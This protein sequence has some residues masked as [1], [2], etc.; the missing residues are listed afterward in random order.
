M[1]GI[2]P[3]M[4]SA[5]SKPEK[6]MNKSNRTFISVIIPT[7]NSA[8]TIGNT[9]QQ[10]FS[11]DFPKE[12]FEVIVVDNG[13]TDAIEQAVKNYPAR[14]L[15][16]EKRGQGPARNLGIKNAKGSIIC[17][18]DSDIIVPNDWLT[19]MSTFLQENPT[20]DAVGGAVLVPKE[21]NRN[22]IQKIMGEIYVK[23]QEFPT[24]I[25]K[26]QYLHYQGSLYTANS[27]Y[28][29]E[30]LEACNGFDESLWKRYYYHD[31]CDIDLSWR[32]VKMGKNLMFNPNIKVYHYAHRTLQG[33]YRQLVGWGA[34]YTMIRKKYG[35]HG[36]LLENLWLFNYFL[37]TLLNAVEAP[38]SK[39]RKRWLNIFYLSS[40]NLGRLIGYHRWK[41][42]RI[43]G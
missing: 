34:V 29:R 10:I 20:V 26:T 33:V 21:G 31:S 12:R 39:P 25:T 7:L 16:C 11:N 42:E 37:G 4:N 6:V 38:F 28:R 41:M 5:F 9:L 22:Y 27:A 32:L 8:K 24:K 3:R 35:W 14:L 15:N 40:F 43:A 2:W 13:S 23:R 30:T 19:K 18:T 36:N 1:E 17:F